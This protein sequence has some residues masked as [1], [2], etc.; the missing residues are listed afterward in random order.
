[1]IPVNAIIAYETFENHSGVFL[2]GDK[3]LFFNVTMTPAFIYA[4]FGDF[5]GDNGG[6]FSSPLKASIHAG[7][8]RLVTR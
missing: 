6:N 4:G 8:G 2:L 1:M 5:K 3:S 7:F